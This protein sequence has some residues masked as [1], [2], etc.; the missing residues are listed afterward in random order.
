MT[1]RNIGASVLDLTLNHPS[2]DQL[3]A[4]IPTAGRYLFQDPSE[5]E[6]GRDG[7]A[8]D[9]QCRSSRSL[10]KDGTTA[11]G[12]IR[13]SDENA[14]IESAV[15]IDGDGAGKVLAFDGV[16]ADG[17][18][19]FE[20]SDRTA[21]CA[22]RLQT[23]GFQVPGTDMKPKWKQ[24]RPYQLRY[25]DGHVERTD[26]RAKWTVHLYP[27]T[28]LIDLISAAEESS[29]FL[30]CTLSKYHR[31]HDLLKKLTGLIR[32]TV[33]LRSAGKQ[34]EAQRAYTLQTD[35]QGVAHARLVPASTSPLH[36]RL[37]TQTWKSSSTR[38]KKV[39]RATLPPSA[40]S[41][42]Q[43]EVTDDQ[44]KL[45]PVKATVYA[46]DENH[47]SF[48]SQQ[49]THVCRK[50]CLLGARPVPLPTRSWKV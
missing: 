5:V 49:H 37:D 29:L 17:W 7:D 28:S 8:V 44:G 26:S 20:Q 25:L 22:I 3:S 16:R 30:P 31:R 38:V 47:P 21:C 13:L 1:I 27:A 48:W 12:A 9:W 34:G 2:N 10:A 4:Y 36:P 41:G 33:S 24:G 19:S 15:W 6:T 35:D 23:I 32:A 14:F 11:T 39:V 43:A 42:F 50:L 40:A 18:F 45:I 46:A